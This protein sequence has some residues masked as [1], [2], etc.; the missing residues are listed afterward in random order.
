MHV[1]NTAGRPTVAPNEPALAVQRRTDAIEAVAF[2]R[3]AL[4]AVL[5]VNIG[6]AKAGSTRT[7]LREVALVGR[8]STKVALLSQLLK[9]ENIFGF[10]PELFCGETDLAIVAARTGCAFGLGSQFASNGIAA[11]IGIVA[12]L[13]GTAVALFAIFHHSIAACPEVFHLEKRDLYDAFH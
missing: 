13:D 7:N 11:R 2:V 9:E 6:R 4:I 5:F 10:A 8:L 1:N 12:F 3:F